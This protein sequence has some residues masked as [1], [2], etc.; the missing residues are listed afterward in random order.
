ML[1]TGIGFAKTSAGSCALMGGLP[2]VRAQLRGA[3]RG[4]PLLVGH[5][6][7]SFLGRLTGALPQALAKGPGWCGS[8]CNSLL[9]RRSCRLRRRL[10]AGTCLPQEGSGASQPSSLAADGR[11]CRAL[12]RRLPAHAFLSFFRPGDC[13][14][15][16]WRA[17][18]A[19]CAHAV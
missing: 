2:H 8:L 12:P 1:R 16:A 18:N 4:M 13:I 11:R 10:R 3:L 9:G 5:S 6:R 17:V 15:L 7:K 19:G 14:A